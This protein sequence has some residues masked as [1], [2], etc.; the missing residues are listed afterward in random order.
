MGQFLDCLFC[1]TGL[2][3]IH[4]LELW[5]CGF[6]ENRGLTMVTVFEWLLLQQCFLPCLGHRILYFPS[7]FLISTCTAY[8]MKYL[9]ILLP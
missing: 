9:K 4:A 7:S 8:L 1:S 6:F 5:V 2:L 3:T